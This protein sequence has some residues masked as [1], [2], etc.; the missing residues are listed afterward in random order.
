MGGDLIRELSDN[1]PLRGA[2]VIVVQNW[3]LVSF[4]VRQFT[5]GA[6]MRQRVK[7]YSKFG[8]AALRPP[9]IAATTKPAASAFRRFS[10]TTESSRKLARPG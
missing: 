1:N 5:G 7:A 2:S 10:I 6:I 3:R 4:H 9:A 8:S